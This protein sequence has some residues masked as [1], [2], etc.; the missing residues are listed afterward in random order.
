MATI[1]KFEDLDA[2]QQARLLCN[3]VFTLINSGEFAKD[4][5]LRDQINGSSGSV[6]D[7]ISEGFERGGTK[8]F[9]HFLYI[10]KSS[11]AEVRSQLY[12]AYDRKYLTKEKFDELFSL[13][14]KI[15][16]MLGGFI[17]YLKQT[18][19]KG[20]KFHEPGETYGLN[21][22]RNAEPETN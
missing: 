1:K 6:M 7:N 20:Q 14:E 19:Y 13:A 22:I 5:K 4:Y 11:C 17:S 2:W 10:S 21:Q 9:I 3:E 18:E 12:R 15:G 16:K 8:E